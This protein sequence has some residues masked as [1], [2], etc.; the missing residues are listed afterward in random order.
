MHRHLIAVKV[1]VERRANQRVDLDCLAFHQHRLECLNAQAVKGWSTIQK[2]W[3]VFND[4]FQDV[5]NNRVLL[6][7]HFF[8]LLDGR[9]V[10]GLLQ[11]VIDERLEKFERHLLGQAALMKL[12]LRADNNDGTPGVVH[13][14]TE[15]VLTETSL[16][17]F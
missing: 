12:E 3:M 16:L 7:D 1:S 14:L 9:A 17:A 10:P 11:P 4:L 2:H 6:L 13:A 15:Q 8:G 5:P